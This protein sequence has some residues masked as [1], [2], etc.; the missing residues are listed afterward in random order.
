MGKGSQHNATRKLSPTLMQH[1]SLASEWARGIYTLTAG[2]RPLARRGDNEE[3][4]ACSQVSASHRSSSQPA[5]E[6]KSTRKWQVSS[7]TVSHHRHK[8]TLASFIT[9]RPQYRYIHSLTCHSSHSQ[10]NF[11]TMTLKLKIITVAP[12]LT[13]YGRDFESHFFLTHKSL[14]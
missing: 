5:T 14:P 11:N 1:W 12:L 4:M 9:Q 6:R 7:V 8:C 2:L 10:M 13:K 3:R